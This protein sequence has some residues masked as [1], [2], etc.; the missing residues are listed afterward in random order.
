MSLERYVRN[1]LNDIKDNRLSSL[2]KYSKKFDGY[3]GDF[4]VKEE[5]FGVIDDISDDD[6]EIIN[7]TIKRIENHHKKQLNQDKISVE[8]GS[9]KGIIYRPIEKIGLYVPGGKPL[10]SSLIMTAVPAKIAG[11]KNIVITTPPYD[12]KVDPHVLYTA[13]ILGIDR[14]YKIGGIQA[15]GAMAYGIC[16]EKR[17]KI[18]GPGNKYVN[19]AKR[20]LFGKVGIDTLAGPSEV[21]IIADETAH[22]DYVEFDLKSQLDHGEGSKA[23]LFTTSKALAEHCRD[24][25]TEVFLKEDLD[26]CMS[27]SNR[28]APE[29]LEILTRNS[30]GLVNKVKNAGAVYLGEYSPTAAGDYFIGTNHVLPTGL[31]ARFSSVLTVDDFRKKISIAQLSR[32]EFLKNKRLGIRLAEIEDMEYHKRSLEVRE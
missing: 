17:D 28:F 1:I 24:F 5:E 31:A 2:E 10:P 3:E 9:L 21:G 26:Q 27:E 6:K 11:V 14:L 16:M 20:Q 7:I 15:V 23:W 18:F 25:A 8:G 30:I 22:K 19:E 12:G 29:H 4:E 13:K 32:N